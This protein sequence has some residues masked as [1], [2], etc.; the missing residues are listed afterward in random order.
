MD[1]RKRTLDVKI[2]PHR[3]KRS[4][5]VAAIY[6]VWVDTKG[7]GYPEYVIEWNLETERVYVNRADRFSFGERVC[8]QP[9]EK[10]N[11]RFAHL[12]VPRS[13]LGHPARLRVS[14]QASDND[15][16]VRS[17]WAP[18]FHRYGKWTRRN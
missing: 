15:A 6:D 17:D 5:G 7:A 9:M 3:T 4:N 14:V 12:N 16:T 10:Y 2:L 1:H 8:E 13:C 11:Y 18:G